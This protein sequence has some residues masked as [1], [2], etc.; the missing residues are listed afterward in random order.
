MY[1]ERLSK[2]DNRKVKRNEKEEN[3]KMLKGAIKKQGQEK[4]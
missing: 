4:G 3:K 1:R 2:K